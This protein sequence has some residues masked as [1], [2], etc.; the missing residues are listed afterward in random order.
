M[1]L[2][3]KMQNN[4]FF[5]SRIFLRIFHVFISH[6]VWVYSNKRKGPNKKYLE[7]FL[8]YF[9]HDCISCFIYTHACV[10]CYPP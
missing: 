8:K 6:M 10:Y 5:V 9:A 1:E 7:G 3:S 2:V 4:L